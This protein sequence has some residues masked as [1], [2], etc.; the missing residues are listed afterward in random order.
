[1][2]ILHFHCENYEQRIQY[3]L[4]SALFISTAEA[5]RQNFARKLFIVFN[6]SPM[7]QRINILFIYNNNSQTTAVILVLVHIYITLYNMYLNNIIY[8]AHTMKHIIIHS[9]ILALLFIFWRKGSFSCLG[10]VLF[11]FFYFFFFNRSGPS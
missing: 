4:M 3:K 10:S 8:R 9:H 2:N 11:S 6:Y 1:M 7:A 5:I